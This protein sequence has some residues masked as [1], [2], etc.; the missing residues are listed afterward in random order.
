VFSA[1]ANTVKI[2]SKTGVVYYVNG[3]RKGT[4]THTYAGI[5]TVTTKAS[6]GSYKL[7]GTQSWKFDNRNAVTPT[8]P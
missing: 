3:V 7:A 8:K 6:T 5:G 1:S 4:G 2:P